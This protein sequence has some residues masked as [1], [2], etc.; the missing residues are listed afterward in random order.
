VKR[1]PP[2]LPKN[3]RPPL[4]LRWS[5]YVGAARGAEWSIPTPVFG[6]G[7]GEPL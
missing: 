2:L 4:D 5:E 6:S 1:I 3:F 7:A